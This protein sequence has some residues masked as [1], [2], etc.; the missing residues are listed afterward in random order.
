NASAMD[1]ESRRHEVIANNLANANSAGFRRTILAVSTR[2]SNAAQAS[3]DVNTNLRGSAAARTYVDFTQGNLINTS[4]KL[5]V[6]INGEGFFVIET[7]AGNMYTR[8][9]SFQLA[10][11]GSIMTTDGMKVLGGGGPL[12]VPADAA[13]TD[14]VI[15]TDGTIRAAGQEI[16]QL[17]VVTFDNLQV[18]QP[19]GNTRFSAPADAAAQPVTA[20]LMQGSLESSNTSLVTE[21]ISMII[22]MRHFEA[23]QQGLRSI[24][25]AIQQFT[26]FDA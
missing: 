3:G 7:P 16:G 9:G 26:T 20:S 14:I 6:A 21:M 17:D 18:L 15:N 12:T 24:S 19:V 1:V 25:E 8:N 10:T 2:G 13:L 11:D 22:G 4:R 5:D 23:A